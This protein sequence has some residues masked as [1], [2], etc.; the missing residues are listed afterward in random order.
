MSAEPTVIEVD[1]ASFEADVVER[2]R[3]VPVLVDFWAP[4]CGPCRVLGPVLERLADEMQGSLVLAKINADEAPTLSAQMGVRGIPN[5]FL[6]KD[7]RMVDGFVGAQPES[8]VRQF[9]AAHV[10]NEADRL[11]AEGDRQL[12]VGNH[13]VAARFYEGAL[14]HD[15]DADGA[16]LGNARLALAAGDY[17]AAE[18]HAARVR[19]SS[20]AFELAQAVRAALKVVEE[21]VAECDREACE[22]RLAADD[23]DLAAR[24]ALAGHEIAAGA[25]RSALE[26]LVTLAEADRGWRK[27]A[28]RRTMLVVFELV[29]A[30]DPLSDEFRDRLRHIY[31]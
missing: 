28:A 11:I 24:Y 22:A 29:G 16:H 8:A 27:E 3:Q 1:E 23:G 20:D 15:P 18:Q 10:P 12:G 17:G 19:P 2:S 30:R 26:H 7:G 31:L 13:E 6:F 9:L 14:M 5:V 21:A 25:Y 4:W